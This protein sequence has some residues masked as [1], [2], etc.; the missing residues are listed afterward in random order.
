M[1]EQA[2]TGH[3]QSGISRR[4][5]VQRSSALATGLL[6]GARDGDAGQVAATSTPAS[7]LPS[8]VL[9]RTGVPV[10]TMTLGTAPCGFAKETP[11]PEIAKI[12]NFA[13]DQGITFIDTAPAYIEA[14]EGVGLALGSRRKDVFLATKVMED[15]IDKAEESLAKSLKLLRTDC[16]DLVYYHSVGDRDIEK[17]VTEDG[18]FSWL[19][20][21]KKAGKFRFLGISGHNRPHKFLPLLETDEVDVLLTLV[22]FVDRHTYGFEE[23]VLPVARKHNVGIVAMKVFGG[24]RRSAGSYENPKAPPELDVAHLEQ[25]VR[26]ALGTPGVATVNLGVHN[27]DQILKNLEMV[28]NFKPLSKDEQNDLDVL[29]KQLAQQWK[30]HFGPVA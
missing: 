15:S 2:M 6:I 28:K 16:V 11:P 24:A 17:G 20:K 19:L 29:G 4:N 1:G 5:F 8:R 18:V 3:S 13:I 22:N 14:E 23:K 12:V 9:G 25:A 30:A 10:T 7:P 21:Q 27:T 26:Y